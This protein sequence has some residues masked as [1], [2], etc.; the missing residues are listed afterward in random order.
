MHSWS[1]TSVFYYSA[2][3]RPHIVMTAG[4]VLA[5]MMQHP[6]EAV[7]APRPELRI[8]SAIGPTASD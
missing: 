3:W 4:C 5:M 7:R 8:L 2:D 6:D 1:S